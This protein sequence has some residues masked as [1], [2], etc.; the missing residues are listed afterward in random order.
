MCQVLAFLINESL[1]E[2]IF[3]DALKVAKVVPIFKA[4]DTKHVTNYRP[5]SVLSTF[6][7][8]YE[9]AVHCRLNK[10][11]TDHAILH[12]N[13]FGFRPKLLSTSLALLQLVDQLTKC[14]DENMITIGVFVD[15]AKAF[16]TVDYNILLKKL[17]H[18][19]VRGIANQ[20][21]CSY[22]KYRQQYVSLD[23][24]TSSLST[25]LCGVPQG[26]ILGPLLFIVYINDSNSASNKLKTL[27][28]ADDT[29]LFHSGKNLIEIEKEVNAELLYVVKW[30]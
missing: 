30:L 10:Y 5:I 17:E 26:F 3:P 15:L 29:N 27:M 12:N 22:L 4:G 21:F 28:F 19:G 20:W 1:S 25:I 11:L 16:D 13:Q 7:K 24:T 18:Y 23:K 6:S 9:K 8:I 2:G 14:M